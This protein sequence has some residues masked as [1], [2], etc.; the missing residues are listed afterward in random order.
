MS[1]TAQEQKV[2]D[3]YNEVS[4]LLEQKGTTTLVAMNALVRVACTI[5]ISGGAS[6][7]DFV[8][9]VR[10]TFNALNKKYGDEFREN[11]KVS[12]MTL[13]EYQE[14]AAKQRVEREA[15][16]E[17]SADRHAR[18]VAEARVK[19]IRNLT[20]EEYCLVAKM[21]EA[22]GSGAYPLDAPVMFNGGTPCDMWTGYCSC[23]GAHKDGI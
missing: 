16:E 14:R 11:G 12:S 22:A 8:A 18:W 2:V 3:C 6:V 5:A 19:G 15:N 9:N 1:I 17:S 7:D 23:G 4:Y 13:G 21:V 10:D 20:A